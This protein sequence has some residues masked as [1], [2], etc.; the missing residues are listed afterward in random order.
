MITQ[1]RHVSDPKR[2]HTLIVNAG[3]FEGVNLNGHHAK[4]I[5]VLTK[6]GKK[7]RLSSNYNEIMFYEEDR[8]PVFVV[9]FE[10]REMEFGEKKDAEAFV[11]KYELE[12][13]IEERK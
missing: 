7:L 1:W 3:V 4:E 11:E 12:T 13:E 9:P 10:G 8:P 2:V 6:D 5:T